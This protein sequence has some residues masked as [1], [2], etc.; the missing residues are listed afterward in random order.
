MY[1]LR[2]QDS[3]GSNYTAAIGTGLVPT[4]VAHS[5][6]PAPGTSLTVGQILP[7]NVTSL[8][9]FSLVGTANGRD[10]EYRKKLDGSLQLK[11]LAG[12]ALPQLAPENTSQ[13]IVDERNVAA[14]GLWTLAYNTPSDP[15]NSSGFGL[16]LSTET[17]AQLL[18]NQR[19]PQPTSPATGAWNPHPAWLG[20]DG[21]YVIT[22]SFVD[23]TNHF[24]GTGLYSGRNGSLTLRRLP[25]QV[26]TD[27]SG[28]FA[29]TITA[30]ETTSTG[31][32]LARVELANISSP[33]ITVPVIGFGNVDNGFKTLVRAGN[34]APGLPGVTFANF[35][36][37]TAQLPSLSAKGDLVF[38]AA[39]AGSG[40]T[41]NNDYSVWFY[42]HSTG[43]SSLLAREGDSFLVDGTPRTISSLE[44]SAPCF[45]PQG[46]N[47]ILKI[48]FTDNALGL[49]SVVA[50][51]PGG[52]TLLVSFGVVLRARRRNG[53]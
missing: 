29:N 17:G 4:V 28:Y 13:F 33:S 25:S 39:L 36:S 52:L 1:G 26:F 35:G 40:V 53:P 8:T 48:R 22:S 12:Q 7:T 10:I 3:I 50:P 21:S 24:Y 41:S 5:G 14:A 42:D 51:E 37:Q 27:E 38:F 18:L 23:S 20:T 16:F 43:T 34:S 46:A 45:D 11:C 6:D 49:F 47:A 2:V 44:F 31:A 15:N 9:S 30:C 32:F 19:D